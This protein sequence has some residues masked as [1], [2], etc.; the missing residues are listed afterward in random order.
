MFGTS[1]RETTGFDG[2]DMLPMD[3]DDDDSVAR[4]VAAIVE[5]TGRL[6]AVV[7][8][9]GWAL[10]GPIEDSPIA[11][12]RAQMETN[13]FGVLRVCRAVL[14]IMREQRAGHTSSRSK[15]ERKLAAGNVPLR[16]ARGVDRARRH[17]QPTP[18]TP[19][20]GETGPARGRLPG[21]LRPFPSQASAGR[22]Q[23]AP[24]GC[25]RGTGRAHPARSAP[26][27]ALQRRHVGSADGAA[28]EALVAAPLVRADS[29]R[30]SGCLPAAK[31]PSPSTTCRVAATAPIEEV[32]PSPKSAA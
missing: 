30:G 17:V 26:G 19:A 31:W 12:A 25:C 5:K 29:R 21:N 1:R 18:V 8:N 15:G 9:A 7:N 32:A 24:A 28:L 13:F 3:V 6:D 10:M 16:S 27:H 20:H 4:A 14:P 2:V 22:G 23:S 11:E